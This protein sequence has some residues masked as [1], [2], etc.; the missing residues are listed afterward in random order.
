MSAGNTRHV[1][2]REQKGREELGDNK[3]GAKA[4]YVRIK[5]NVKV[6]FIKINK[7]KF[8]KKKQIF[9]LLISLIFIT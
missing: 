7:N 4:D 8:Y 6:I 5:R 2:Q 1:G 3:D 9:Q